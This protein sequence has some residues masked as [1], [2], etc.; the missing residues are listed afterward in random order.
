MMKVKIFII[1]SV[2]ISAV[3]C[4]NNIEQNSVISVDYRIENIDRNM[5]RVDFILENTDSIDYFIPFIKPASNYS[6]FTCKDSEGIQDNLRAEFLL[7]KKSISRKELIKSALIDSINYDKER[8]TLFYYFEEP[9]V[10]EY[11]D[12]ILKHYKDKKE[13]KMIYPYFYHAIAN[14]C[15]YLKSGESKIISNYIY[16]YYP[17]GINDIEIIFDFNTRSVSYYKEKYFKSI[18]PKIENY[19][20]FKGR[21]QIANDSKIK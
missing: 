20:L 5:I 3:F 8:D 10:E 14:G 19:Y 2:I 15:L 6:S 11:Y 16:H 17:L 18:P 7:T 21:I 12:R 9:F 13:L 4:C 1:L